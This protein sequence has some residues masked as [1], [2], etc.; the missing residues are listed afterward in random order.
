MEFIDESFCLIYKYI[1]TMYCTRWKEI[2]DRTDL[3]I[4][5]NKCGTLNGIERSRGW[6]GGE[7]NVLMFS[8]EEY[9]SNTDRISPFYR[10]GDLVLASRPSENA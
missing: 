9:N 10:K 5:D 6:R 4:T 8:E 2:W 3:T 7:K 1:C